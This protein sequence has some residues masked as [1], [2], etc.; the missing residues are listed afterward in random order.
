MTTIITACLQNDPRVLSRVKRERMFSEKQRWAKRVV[1]VYNK[2]NCNGRE[3]LSAS[4][5]HTLGYLP[6][7]TSP[8]N[9]LQQRHPPGR[10]VPFLLI[11]PASVL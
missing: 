1:E 8:A 11:T 4:A 5:K 9:P 7:D 6:P 10:I 2:H 3:A